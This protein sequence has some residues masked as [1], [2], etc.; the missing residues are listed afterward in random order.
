METEQILLNAARR[1]DRDALVKIFELYAPALYQYALRL[2]GNLMFADQIVGDVFVK[3]LEQFSVGSGPTANLRA[4]LY[5]TTYHQIID[6]VRASRRWA[7]LEAADWLQQDPDSVSLRAEDQILF[8]QMICIIRNELTADQR[9]V[10]ILRFL[11]KFS[12]RKTA[13]I[14]GKQVS[15]VKM[16]QNRALAKLRACLQF[17]EIRKAVSPP[18]LELSP[19]GE[20]PEA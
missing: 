20:K 15:H 17:K 2:C 7:P 3:L 8:G 10:I 14:L 16:I 13:A 12:L 1:M 11:E 6:E 5:A 4:Y 18:D 19:T 9:H